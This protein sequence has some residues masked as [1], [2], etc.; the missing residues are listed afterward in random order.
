[1][2]ACGVVF[3]SLTH[4]ASAAEYSSI[5]RLLMEA[6]DAPTGSAQGVVVGPI[7]Q[8]FRASTG[9]TA[10]VR[11]EVTTIKRFQQEGCKRLNVRLIQANVMAANGKPTEFAI[12]YGLNLCRDGSP[13]TEGMDIGSVG[14]ALRQLHN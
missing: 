5:K 11:A 1:M 12:D 10:P 7:A 4:L 9:S 8:Q 3:M 2:A 14:N 13:P 6:I